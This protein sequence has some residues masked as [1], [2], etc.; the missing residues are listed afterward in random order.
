MNMDI[1]KERT[2]YEADHRSRY[3]GAEFYRHGV[4]KPYLASN[5]QFAWEAWQTRAA[6]AEATEGKLKA[7]IAAL[8]EA[9][10]MAL[11]ALDS[12]SAIVSRYD[13]PGV[14]NH[15]SAG[16]AP[17]IKALR[18]AVVWSA[19]PQPAASQDT[20]KQGMTPIAC[21]AG[22]NISL[23][24]GGPLKEGDYYELHKMDMSLIAPRPADRPDTPEQAAAR[25][26][27]TGTRWTPEEMAVFDKAQSMPHLFNTINLIGAPKK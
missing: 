3:V 16:M 1:E 15:I 13:M 20:P 18:A 2:A 22:G 8:R 7:E 21:I 9:A 19:E 17:A 24:M 25:K 5:A 23:V 26:Y 27:F 11:E 14:Q 4:N 12:A 10:Q 6:Q